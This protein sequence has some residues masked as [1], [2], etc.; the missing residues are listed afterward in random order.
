MGD[1]LCCGQAQNGVNF[2]FK[3]NLTLMVKV[4]C[5]RN[6]RDL[7]Q[8]VCMFRPNLVSL[9]WTGGIYVREDNDSNVKV[10]ITWF[11]EIAW[12]TLTSAVQEMPL[13]L[14]A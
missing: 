4:D 1:E 8:S 14:I 12:S 9:A 11:I 10:L 3:L 5:P 6:N 2:D 13:K 7:N